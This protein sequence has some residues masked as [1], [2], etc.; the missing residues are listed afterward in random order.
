MRSLLAAAIAGV[1]GAV[2]VAVLV[3]GR[4]GQAEL[5]TFATLDDKSYVVWSRIESYERAPSEGAVH[6]RPQTI[7][8]TWQRLDRGTRPETIVAIH[9]LDGVLLSRGRNVGGLAEPEVVERAER[10]VWPRPQGHS[11]F[12][13]PPGKTSWRCPGVWGGLELVPSERQ[14]VPMCVGPYRR[15]AAGSASSAVR[16]A[17]PIDRDV[18]SVQQELRLSPAGVPLSSLFRALLED[19]SQVV[20]ASQHY[21]VKI[22]PLSE[23]DVIEEL[24]F[25]N[26][27]QQ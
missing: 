1:M 27:V 13:V 22:L 19:G 17:W 14:D 20:I 3:L 2:L 12:D 11:G 4:G 23:W 25:G 18:I 8:E 16:P 10:R 5:L 7:E 9:T 6:P 26:E 24:V 21:H 15:P